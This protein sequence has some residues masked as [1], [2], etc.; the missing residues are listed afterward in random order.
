MTYWQFHAAFLL[1]ALAA[2][3]GWQHWRGYR[4]PRRVWLGIATAAAI[5]LVYT[6]PWDNYLVQ[7]GV[8]S[9]R[10]DRV[11]LPW[12]LG[13]V[14]LEEYAFF[15][16]QPFLAGLCLWACV[17]AQTHRW[18]WRLPHRSWRFRL[19]G[20]SVAALLCASGILALA[21]GGR[22]LY[23]GLIL[24]WGSPPLA[25]HWLYGGDLLWQSRGPGLL[26]AGLSTGY[27]WTADRV[28]IGAGIWSISPLHSTG[29]SLAGLPAEEALF[30][31]VTN[32]LIIQTLL[33][34]WRRFGVAGTVVPPRP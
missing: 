25:L 4:A 30:F 27:L 14:P 16:L 33:L 9:Y 5:A 10:P 17:P 8:W 15:V 28:A 23:A 18:W 21:V 20:A 31:L 11:A 12:R 13:Y 2:L 29:W 7:R 34:L 6:T 26:A 22:W 1:P 3:L 19:A 32:L 24:V